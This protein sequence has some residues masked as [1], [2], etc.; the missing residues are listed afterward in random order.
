MKLGKYSSNGHSRVETITD[1]ECNF[2]L[3]LIFSVDT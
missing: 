2:G 1:I 3:G